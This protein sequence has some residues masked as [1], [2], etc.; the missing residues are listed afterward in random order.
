MGWDF[1]SRGGGTVRYL[2]VVVTSSPPSRSRALGP[3]APP[4]PVDAVVFGEALV[5]FF[6]DVQEVGRPLEEVSH[7]RRFLGGA[8]AN[9]AVGLARQGVPTALITQVGG[10]AFGRFVQ[11][12]L[13]EE[14][15]ACDGML[16]HA[17]ARTGVTFVSLH[18]GGG[19]RSFLFYRH[20]SADMLIA[21]GQVDEKSA[22][23]RR[24]RLF[25]FGSST[26]SREPSRAATLRALE[27][28]CGKGPE[29]GQRIVS[30]DLNLRP[31]LWPEI[32]DAPPLL[33]KLLADCDIV[34]L[35]P[36]ELPLLY[37]T[38]N[39][40]EA[41]AKARKAGTTVVAVTLGESG[42]YLDSPAGQAYFAAEPILPPARAIDPTGAGDAFSAGLVASLLLDVMVRDP[43][44]P[45]ASD[46]LRRRLQSLSTAQVKQAASHA[47]HLGAMACTALGATTAVP[48]AA[49]KPA[50][51]RPAATAVGKSARR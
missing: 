43:E 10:D 15:V 14:G 45:A 51:P 46:D 30:C 50:S 41:A 28:A 4:V 13:T 44:D 21:P 40:E 29:R 47:S 26:L 20:P 34:K 49:P 19:G 37:G 48:K 3:L 38:E 7:F 27:I 32:K 6:P 31:H 17:S 18:S 16:T 24:G 5:D 25:H 11:Q 9:F 2:Q 12:A 1:L 22:F 36:E 8:P 33:R 39:V 23:V 42:C 35:V